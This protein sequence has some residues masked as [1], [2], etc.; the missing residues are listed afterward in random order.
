MSGVRLW[1]TGVGLVARTLMVV[2]ILADRIWPGDHPYGLLW[3]ILLAVL[4]E[5]SDAA[6]RHEELK[7]K[8]R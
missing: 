8:K 1:H 6:A 2:A 7:E 4:A 5:G 3:V